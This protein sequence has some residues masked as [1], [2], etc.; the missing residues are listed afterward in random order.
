MSSIDLGGNH[1]LGHMVR[2]N[3]NLK[4]ISIVQCNNFDSISKSFAL[5]LSSHVNIQEV[6]ISSVKV[7][8][9]FFACMTEV[10]MKTKVKKIILD[11]IG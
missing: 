2:E 6:H 9:E 5:N 7:S 3:T 8:G 1:D 11:D 10:I 4:K